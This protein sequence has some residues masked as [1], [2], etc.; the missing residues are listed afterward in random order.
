MIDNHSIF[1]IS[2]RNT[3][4]AFTNNE[5]QAIDSVCISF[6]N[7]GK[8]SFGRQNRFRFYPSVT[9]SCAGAV[10]KNNSEKIITKE[11][12]NQHF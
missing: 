10:R 8:Y 7:S 12:K 11:S 9:L 2:R 4:A 5:V 3:G 6:P 1:L